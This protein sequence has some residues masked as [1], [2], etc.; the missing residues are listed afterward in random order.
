MRTTARAASSGTSSGWAGG[1]GVSE[2]IALPDY[3]KHCGVPRSIDDGKVGRGVPDIA[4]SATNY[5]TRVDGFEG[6][7][8]GTSAAKLRCG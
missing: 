4:M 5:F 7:S 3:Q 8:G 1:G 6:A 2:L